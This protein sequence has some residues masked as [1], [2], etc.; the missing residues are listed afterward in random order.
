VIGMI[1]NNVASRRVEMVAERVKELIG[2]LM[3]G[4]GVLG[5]IEPRRH[6][7]LWRRGPAPW[8]MMMDPFIDRPGLTRCIGAAEAILGLWLASR[9]G[10]SWE[11]A[12]SPRRSRAAGSRAEMR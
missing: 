9:Q 1:L 11:V 3:I 4:D 8:Q 12:D 2:M 6:I 5:L 10:D 7:G